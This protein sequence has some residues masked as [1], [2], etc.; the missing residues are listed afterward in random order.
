MVTARYC[1]IVHITYITSPYMIIHTTNG[2]D[3]QKCLGWIV[4]NL[5]SC[6]VF[7]CP[8]SLCPPTRAGECELCGGGERT[9]ASLE[10]LQS[11]NFRG[12]YKLLKELLQTWW[13]PW[14]I[15][16]VL[17]NTGYVSQQHLPFS[18]LRV[19]WLWIDNISLG[20][21]LVWCCRLWANCWV[22]VATS[23]DR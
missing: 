4:W 10:L 2:W 9:P 18:P 1:F 22:W 13:E 11:A 15:V 19:G 21:V 14:H 8:L 17:Y 7:K 16:C 20:V 5:P 12:K 23:K 6:F 3:K